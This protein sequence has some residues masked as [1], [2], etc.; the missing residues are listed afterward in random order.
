MTVLTGY[1]TAAPMGGVVTPALTTAMNQY[2]GLLWP[3]ETDGALDLALV[4]TLVADWSV[5]VHPRVISGGIAASYFDDY[6]NRIHILP[7]P[8]E[9]GDVLADKSVGVAVWNSYLVAKDITAATVPAGLGMTIT[10]P[11][12][13]TIPFTLTPLREAIFTLSASLTGPPSVD[14]QIVF[15]IGGVDFPVGVTA[16]RVVVFPF[17]PNWSSAYDETFVYNSWVLAAGDG[18][19]Q[20]GSNW[21]NQPRR[22]FDYTIAVRGPDMQKLENL[23]FSC[24][25]RFFGI[26]HWADKSKLTAPVAAGSLVLPLD[27]TDRSFQVGNLGIIYIDSDQFEAFEIAE[28]TTG[29]LSISSPLRSAWPAGARVYPVSLGLINENSS[30]AYQTDNT[31]VMPVSFDCEPSSSPINTPIGGATPTYRGEELYL[32]RLDWKAALTFSQQSDREVVDYNTGKVKSFSYSGFSKKTRKH[33][34]QVRD[35]AEARDF[36]AWLGRR[37][38]VARPVYMPSGVTDFTL[39]VDIVSGSNVLEVVGNEYGALVGPAAARRDIIILLR[40]GTY[41]ARR[42]DSTAVLVSGHLQLTLDAGITQSITAAQ[43]KRISFLGFYRLAANA[44]TIR[45]LTDEVGVVESNLITK[46]AP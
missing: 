26:P 32:G 46:R 8:I 35:R 38:G 10:A 29:S 20:T 28:V 31:V 15:T 27:T 1:L 30:G 43:I 23:L 14:A 22:Q 6:Y 25:H 19:E 44:N 11:A 4:S 33:N 42:I 12:G 7:N 39:V 17:A 18:T 9:V 5:D 13:D 36:R 34:W 41:F 2:D 21:G 16:R 24:Q 3:P 37:E 45:W 40:D